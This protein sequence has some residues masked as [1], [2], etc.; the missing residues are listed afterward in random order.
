[1]QNL[2]VV[3]FVLGMVAIYIGSYLLNNNTPAPDGIEIE[4][5]CDMCKHTECTKKSKSNSNFNK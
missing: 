5:D 4:I 2:I 1:M 3:L